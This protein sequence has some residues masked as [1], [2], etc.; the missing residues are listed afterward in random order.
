MSEKENS[1][2]VSPESTGNSSQSISEPV[3]VEPPLSQIITAPPL[4]KTEFSNKTDQNKET[5]TQLI[6]N[7]VNDS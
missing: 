6:D 2:S 4:M 3:T 5:R 7:V 1:I